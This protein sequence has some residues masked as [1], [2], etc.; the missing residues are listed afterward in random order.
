MNALCKPRRPSL[1]DFHHAVNHSRPAESLLYMYPCRFWLTSEQAVLD[2]GSSTAA[3]HGT[4]SCLV[5]VRW[6][7]CWRLSAGPAGALSRALPG[8]STCQHHYKH[9]ADP[10]EIGARLIDADMV[11]FI[12]TG[13]GRDRW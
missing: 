9:K 13:K 4:C 7:M 5:G 6:I 12:D 3:H 2:F 10:M 11:L 8:G 1:C